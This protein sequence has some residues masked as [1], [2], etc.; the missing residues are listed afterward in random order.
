MDATARQIGELVRQEAD[1]EATKPFVVSIMGQTGTGKTSLI[2]A[3]F[4]TSLKTDSVRPCTKDVEKVVIPG[5]EGNEL[6]FYD[7]PGIGEDGEVDESYIH[8]YRAKLLESDVVLWTIHADSRSVAFD[9]LALVRILGGDVV[10]RGGLMRKLTFVLTKVDLLTPPPWIFAMY[11][12]CGI[13]APGALTTELLSQKEKYYQDSFILPYADLIV[14]TTHH[15]G[16]FD[17][18]EPSLVADK[19]FVTYK[20]FLSREAASSLAGRYPQHAEV[21]GRL[22]DN[23]CVIPC[24][25]LFRFN[26]AQLLL[27]IVNKLGAGAIARFKNF[28]SGEAL[29]EVPLATARTFCNMIV[30]D[31][32]RRKSVFDMVQHRL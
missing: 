18:N 13:F 31:Q 24:S 2:N 5:V 19:Y 26:L 8:Q 21:F 16:T 20:G 32:K 7:L 15:D 17:A 1:K 9:Q 4:G 22:Y 25:S 30:F 23:Y 11:R 14:S 12:D 3:I 29:N 27:V 6:W 28:A 10:E